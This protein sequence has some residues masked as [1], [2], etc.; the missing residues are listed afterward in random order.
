[1]PRT[2]KLTDE[3]LLKRLELLVQGGNKLSTAASSLGIS[4]Q[5]MLYWRGEAAKGKRRYVE[6]FRRM[7]V[8]AD[9]GEVNDV[10]VTAR[11]AN[12]DA[13]HVLCPHCR[14]EFRITTDELLALAGEL[15]AA[16]NVKASAAQV[17][18]QRLALRNPKQWSPRVT[19]TVE[20]E[21]NRLLDVLQAKLA[22]EV[23]RLVVETYLAATRD[24]DEAAAPRREP[25][26]GGLH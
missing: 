4:R 25:G 13:A 20:E 6:F 10:L 16:Q 2:S 7:E 5:T 22:P 19:V 23:F 18:F 24:E 26:T 8:A 12:P 21:H 1:V 11:A 9:Q 15:A 3:K 17:A 14:H